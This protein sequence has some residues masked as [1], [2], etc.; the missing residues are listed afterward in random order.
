MLLG[1]ER[2]EEL[3]A[4]DIEALIVGARDDFIVPFHH[5]E[6]LARRIRNAMLVGAV[7]GHF[8]PQVY[9]DVFADHVAA[10]LD[11]RAA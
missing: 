1:Y 4:L 9:P 5:S 10:F 8:F 7:G 6:D 3:A 2:S 11:R